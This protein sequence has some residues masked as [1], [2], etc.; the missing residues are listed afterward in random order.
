MINIEQFRKEVKGKIFTAVF[1]KKDGT[2]RTMRARLGVKKGVS[3]VG[4]K[5]SPEER[6]NLIV[7]DMEKKA[8][9]TIYLDS[10]CQLNYNKKREVFM[11]NFF[12]K[13]RK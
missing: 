9:R 5:Y 4:L 11:L 10:L 8:F 2:M 3:G 13:E 12:K 6:G 1:I 7:F